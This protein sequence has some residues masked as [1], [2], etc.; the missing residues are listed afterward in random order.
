MWEQAI[1]CSIQQEILQLEQQSVFPLNVHIETDYED[2]P[3][4]IS[5]YSE[6]ILGPDIFKIGFLDSMDSFSRAPG[7]PIMEEF[8]EPYVTHWQELENQ[9]QVQ[10]RQEQEEHDC[11]LSEH[12]EEIGGDVRDDHNFCYGADYWYSVD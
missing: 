3:E 9:E 6:E 11:N 2:L 1:Y 4:L 10:Q 8:V 12:A 5:E 7:G